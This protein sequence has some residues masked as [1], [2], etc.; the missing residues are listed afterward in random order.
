MIASSLKDKMT[1]GQKTRVFV[2]DSPARM[3]VIIAVMLFAI[4]VAINPKSL[5]MSALS[6]ILLLTLLLS[7]AS[8]GQTMVL[9][10]AG[11]DFTVGA[12]MSS[13]AILTTYVMGGQDGRFLLV[14]CL[15]MA[16]G[17]AVGLVNGLCAIKID[18]PPMIVTM[19]ISNVLTRSS[20]VLTQ[21]LPSGWAGPRFVNSVISK[22]GGFAVVDAV[23]SGGVPLIFFLLN[24]SRFGKQLY[25][26]GNNRW[27]PWPASGS[28]D[29]CADVRVLGDAVGLC[30]RDRRRLH[31]HGAL[32]DFDEYAFSSLVAVIV[33][34][35]VQR[36][37]RQLCRQHRGALLMV[38]LSNGL[39]VLALSQPVRNIVQGTVMVLLLILYN[40]LAPCGNRRRPLA[41]TPPWH[42]RRAL[43]ANSGSACALSG[44]W[45]PTGPSRRRAPRSRVEGLA[46]PTPRSAES[47]RRRS[48]AAMPPWA[49]PYSSRSAGRSCRCG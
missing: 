28:T 44:R 48:P 43:R 45:A 23:R 4:T 32:P 16:M 25:L 6:S 3:A 9:I 14:F 20:Y 17:A 37:H 13:A 15:A 42:T 49:R 2:Q 41:T 30:G 29:S 36:Q 5:N 47:D 34:G 31:G 35:V 11:L 24:R 26:M 19:A 33:G 22:I 39:T 8:A 10:G 21:G 12:M 27:R 46:G 38:V 1:L 18:L 7:F 40:T